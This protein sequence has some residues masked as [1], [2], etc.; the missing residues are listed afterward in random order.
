MLAILTATV[1]SA[2]AAAILGEAAPVAAIGRWGGYENG[3]IPLSALT[4]VPA[5]IGGYL[6]ND[7]AVAYNNFSAEF[8]GRF[9]KALS[10]TEGYRTY[11]RQQTLWNA[12]QNGTGNL[13]A[14]PGTSNHGWALACDFGSGVNSYGTAEKDWANANGPRFGWVPAGDGFSYQE[15]WHFEY[16]LGDQAPPPGSGNSVPTTTKGDGMIVLANTATNQWVAAD[17]GRWD[18]IPSGQGDLYVALAGR[19]RVPLSDPDFT[20]ARDYFVGGKQTDT[21]VYAAPNNVWYLI[22][23][24]VFYAIPSGQGGIFEGAFGPR[25]PID[26]STFQALQAAFQR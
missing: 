23:P 12:Y 4:P 7:A 9:G 24:G 10:I 8:R 2:A 17:Q 3:K 18:V 25:Q 11:E 19:D 5:S 13:A 1:G 16:V 14:A 22:G 20:R 15:P 6:R 21:K 26:N